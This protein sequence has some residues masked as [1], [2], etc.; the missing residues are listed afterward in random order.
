[1]NEAQMYEESQPMSRKN[2]RLVTNEPVE[3][4]K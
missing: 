3:F 2:R 4:E 1:V